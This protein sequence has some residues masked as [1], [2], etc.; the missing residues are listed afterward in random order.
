VAGREEGVHPKG[1]REKEEKLASTELE[2]PSSWVAQ[3]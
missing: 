3:C 1:P 2:A